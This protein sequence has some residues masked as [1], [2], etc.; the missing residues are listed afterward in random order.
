MKAAS[1]LLAAFV[2]DVCSAFVG[3]GGVLFLVLLFFSKQV[4]SL[5]A[6]AAASR[7]PLRIL[8]RCAISSP[9]A[10]K[11]LR[12]SG[13]GVS[14]YGN[15]QCKRVWNHE[16]TCT[17]LRSKKERPYKTK[18]HN[19]RN[20][21]PETAKNTAP[22]FQR[23]QTSGTLG[24]PHVV[25]TLLYLRLMRRLKRMSCRD[26]KPLETTF[27]LVFQN[28]PPKNTFL[29]TPKNTSQKTKPS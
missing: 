7:V 19:S 27:S 24:V 13:G 14:S 28:L 2:S 16:A 21:G 11:G 12:A 18:Q 29:S 5:T 1:S 22:F 15:F 17:C 10:L 4:V 23:S 20:S 3:G 9:V 26:G 25:P 8:G 6:S